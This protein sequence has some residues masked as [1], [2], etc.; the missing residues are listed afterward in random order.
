MRRTPG[1]GA[2]R[3]PLVGARGSLSE[4]WLPQVVIVNLAGKRFAGQLPRQACHRCWRGRLR[5]GAVL[6]RR[7]FDQQI[8]RPCIFAGLQ[9]RAYPK[10]AGGVIVTAGTIEDWREDRL[11]GRLRGWSSA[12]GFAPPGV[13]ELPPAR[14]PTTATTVTRPTSRTQNLGS[15]ARPT[16][17]PDGTRSED[18][19]G[20][21]HRRARAR[22]ANG[23]SMRTVR[24]R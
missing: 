11:R 1:A 16:T 18:Q 23:G 9:P 5:A 24:S 6:A 4:R 17:R 21:P 19:G 8:S 13:D 22:Y 3:L 7:F 15:S 12:N 2:R 10:W 14:A 20:I